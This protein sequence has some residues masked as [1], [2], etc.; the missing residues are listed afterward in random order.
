[1]SAE[2][3]VDVYLTPAGAAKSQTRMTVPLLHP[4]AP[5]GHVKVLPIL[6]GAVAAGN[7]LSVKS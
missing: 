2:S 1:M 6:T 7:S 3:K 4:D 5:T